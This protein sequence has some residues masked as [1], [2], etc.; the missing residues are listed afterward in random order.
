MIQDQIM[1]E[2][3]QVH[4][5]MVRMVLTVQQQQESPIP[6]TQAWA[7]QPMQPRAVP[8]PRPVQPTAQ[9]AAIQVKPAPAPRHEVQ[10]LLSSMSGAP[11]NA[12][13][14]TQT[15]ADPWAQARERQQ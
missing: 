9:P 3:D 7:D 1:G 11:L 5:Q 8:P 2:A 13:F 6:W 14:P 15:G 10:P 4:N 12:P